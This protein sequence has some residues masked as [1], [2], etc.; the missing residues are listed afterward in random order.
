MSY[1]FINIST[2]LITGHIYFY[3]KK[4]LKIENIRI[5]TVYISKAVKGK[6][7]NLQNSSESPL[8]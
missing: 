5:N 2:V 6:I 8:L 4:R 7:R 3:Y 1:A